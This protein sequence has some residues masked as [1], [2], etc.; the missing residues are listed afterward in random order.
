MGE[1]MQITILCFFIQ[2]AI[3]KSIAES[4]RLRSRVSQKALERLEPYVGK[5]TSTVLRG[6]RE[7][8]TVLWDGNIPRLPDYESSKATTRAGYI[9]KIQIR[10]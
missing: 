1:E 7:L 2:T 5:L 4:G 6:A 9:V 8:V 3:G 10:K